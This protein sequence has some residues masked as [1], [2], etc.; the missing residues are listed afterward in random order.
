MVLMVYNVFDL[1]DDAEPVLIRTPWCMLSGESNM[2]DTVRHALCQ[3]SCS[4]AFLTAQ[5]KWLIVL[6]HGQD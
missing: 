3:V 4:K 1:L 5:S 2:V 6:L